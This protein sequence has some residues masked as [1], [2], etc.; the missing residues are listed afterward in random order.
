ME[1]FAFIWRF[2]LHMLVGTAYFAALAL[3][4]V[5]LHYFVALLEMLS[6]PTLMIWVCILF[7]YVLFGVDGLLF[8]IFVTVESIR[9][10]RQLR[11]RLNED[12]P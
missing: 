12:Q 5:G 6:L 2:V 4:A 7:E 11:R 10:S 3:V 8:V 1:P 9:L